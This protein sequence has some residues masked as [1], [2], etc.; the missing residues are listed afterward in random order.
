M[1]EIAGINYISE[2]IVNQ[3]GNPDSQVILLNSQNSWLGPEE[4]AMLMALYS[5]S[6]NSVFNH[7][8]DVSDKGP[9]KFMETYYVEYGHASIGDCTAGV[10]LFFE[11]VSMLA[12]KAIQDYALYRGQ[13]CSTRYINFSSQPF[14][15]PT[16]GSKLEQIYQD[17]RSFYLGTTPA[18]VDYLKQ[19][20]PFEAQVDGSTSLTTYNKAI[21]ARAFDI[22]RGFLP[23]GASTNVAWAA[24]LRDIA[25]HSVF[26][27]NH[28]LEE[29]RNIADALHSVARSMYP[30][31]FNHRIYPETEGYKQEESRGYYHND[32]EDPTKPLEVEFEFHNWDIYPND[33][34]R[35]Y[36]LL[37]NRPNSHT[38]LSKHFGR[39]GNALLA[40]P[41][42]FGSFRDWQRQRS[43]NTNMPLLTDESFHPW[44]LA[45][46]PETLQDLAYNHLQRT[47]KQ[48]ER[49]NLSSEVAQYAT[50]MGY[51]VPVEVSASLDKLVYCLELRTNKSV[52]PTLRQPMQEISKRLIEYFKGKGIDLALYSDLEEVDFNLA[53]G[54][55]DI[56][57]KEA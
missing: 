12:A 6:P 30:N 41:L 22:M 37:K 17:Q 55:Q 47:A 42:D 49:L 19:I 2:P 16:E 51:Q 33:F 20:Y 7:L 53:R 3:G 28:P 29:V 18:L 39:L 50:E 44:Y 31:S 27:R 45:E 14:I 57:K 34:L 43:V 8:K 40:F 35:E 15:D 23:A 48:R 54:N 9:Q 10:P 46:L 13:E 36:S 26:L 11:G 38:S 1:K 32:S 21:N 24:S 5:R 52:H 4:Q 25:D 56:V